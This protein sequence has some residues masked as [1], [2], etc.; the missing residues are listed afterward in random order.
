MK[1]T[2]AKMGHK[3]ATKMKKAPAKFNKALKDASASG[4]LDKSPRFKAAVDASSI[5]MKKAAMKL[6]KVSAMK[7]K[8]KSM[9]K[10]SHKK[11]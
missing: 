6:K 3:S 8:A 10:M 7:M 9:A 2:P 4:K 5:K 1:K 11:K